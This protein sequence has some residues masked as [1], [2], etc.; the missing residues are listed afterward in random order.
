MGDNVGAGGTVVANAS[1]KDRSTPPAGDDNG[2]IAIL[3]QTVLVGS[4]GNDTTFVPDSAGDTEFVQPSPHHVSQEVSHTN[5]SAGAL[6]VEHNSK[7]G[8]THYVGSRTRSRPSPLACTASTH[9][10]DPEAIL[11][12]RK[13]MSTSSLRVSGQAGS[14]SEAP[15]IIT[16]DPVTANQIGPNTLSHLVEDDPLMNTTVLGDGAVCP[17]NNTNAADIGLQ[18]VGTSNHCDPAHPDGIIDKTSSRG[19]SLRDIPAPSF[20]LLREYDDDGNFIP[21]PRKRRAAGLPCD[22]IQTSEDLQVPCHFFRL[23]TLN[24]ATKTRP[25][26]SQ[27]SMSRSMTTDVVE[28]KLDCGGGYIK[29]LDGDMDQKKFGGGHKVKFAVAFHGKLM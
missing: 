9:V 3:S 11:R 13:K 20:R 5:I 7:G 23:N 18:N 6:Y 10:D 15:L 8:P 19:V 25:W 21:D 2:S 12:K 29:L 27:W 1:L 22:G 24:S 14:D 17:Q 28:Q 16:D 26:C 4:S